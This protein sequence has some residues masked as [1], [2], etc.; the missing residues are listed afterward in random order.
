MGIFVSVP[1]TV[2]C[3]LT[4]LVFAVLLSLSAYKALGVL[5]S[6][7]YSGK[8][9]FK[10]IRK[11]GNLAQQRLILLALLCLLSC[12][13][14]SLCFSFTG[15]W[16]AVIGLIPYIAFFTVYM[17][18]D[19]KIALRS[20]VTRTARFT[21]LYVVLFVVS[22]IISYISVT[23][24]NF[25]DCVWGNSI[26][27]SLRYCALAILPAVL[28]LLIALSN[29]IAKI[30]EVPR[31]KKY[32]KSAKAKL[33]ASNIKVIGITGSYGKTST[34]FILNKILSAKYKV[35]STPR[36]H[37]TPIGIALAINSH[38]LSSY[39]IFV[40][41]MGARNVGDI[42]ELCE[43]C[44]PDI[45]VITGICG[46]HLETFGTF[47][48]VVKAKG[49]ILD[50]TKD[51]AVIADD[52][53]D[54]FAERAA[55]MRRCDCV[56][57]I[58]CSP[59]GVKFTLTLGGESKVCES[60]LLGR[61]SAYNI[62]IAAQT[63]YLAGMTLDE[64]A[65]AIPQIEFIEHRLQLIKSNGVNILDDG[66]NSNVRGARAALEVLRSFGGRK[67]AVTPGLVELGV[68]EEDENKELGKNLVGLDL[69]I[70]VG[71]TLIESVKS[72]Y[73][74]NGGD[75]EKLVTVPTLQ[76]AQERIKEYINTG[77]TVLF[78]NDLPDIV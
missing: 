13:I 10:W 64:I 31:N 50:A 16:S 22:F 69:V 70:L 48:N 27:C 20:A 62:A 46:Q 34:K 14:V 24:L 51:C 45:S 21:R 56:S 76:A 15:E 11:K 61:H 9:F 77:D 23:L 4:A 28:Y 7:G 41:E 63:A 8:K 6:A 44:P 12:G 78:L 40:A 65:S 75:G 18:A 58:S 73:L 53:Y 32:V 19:R 66:Y 1:K 71:D 54:L 49:E 52:C 68:L 74:E 26:F 72:G 5:Q 38:E 47:A 33:S 2:E 30:Y 35:L 59:E 43:I 29:L 57:D 3:I 39:D 25:A 60:R 42:A 37:N 67:I 17:V 36:S 55:N